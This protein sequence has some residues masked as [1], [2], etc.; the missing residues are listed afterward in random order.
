MTSCR[1]AGMDSQKGFA[2]MLRHA[3][4]ALMGVSASGILC[5]ESALA[6]NPHASPVQFQTVNYQSENS[7]ASTKLP[8]AMS[9]ARASTAST[10]NGPKGCYRCDASGKCCCNC[11]PE[12]CANGLC[13]P[14]CCCCSSDGKCVVGCKPGECVCVNCPPG[15]SC[16]A[17]ASIKGANDS[18]TLKRPALR[19]AFE[20]GQNRAHA[21]A[22][23]VVHSTMWRPSFPESNDSAGVSAAP[24]SD[25]HYQ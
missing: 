1:A 21:S 14:G 19:P 22:V 24:H 16:P 23:L 11:T 15:C 13:P 9:Q 20:R 4:F 5:A 8:R 3:L 25:T 17:C 6:Q 7:I 12:D 18:T 2:F 10:P